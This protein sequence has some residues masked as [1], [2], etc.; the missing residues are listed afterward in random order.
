MDGRMEWRAERAIELSP[1]V[2]MS[3]R[4][5]MGLVQ[6]CVMTFLNS[7]RCCEKRSRLLDSRFMAMPSISA[8]LAAAIC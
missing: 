3:V 4:V 6:N 8:W 1:P 7:V 2:C 5:Y